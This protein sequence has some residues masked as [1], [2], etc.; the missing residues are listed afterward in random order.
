M[1]KGPSVTILSE[2]KEVIDLCVSYGKNRKSLVLELWQNLKEL[3]KVVQK[4][5]EHWNSLLME[6]M[7]P[8][9]LGS[10]KKR[11]D[12]QEW[13]R[14][15]CLGPGW[16]GKI[17]V[18][19]QGPFPLCLLGFVN[20]SIYNIHWTHLLRHTRDSDSGLETSLTQSL[21]EKAPCSDTSD[22]NPPW[23]TGDGFIN[24]SGDEEISYPNKSSTELWPGLQRRPC[25]PSEPAPGYSI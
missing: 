15:G 18:P 8:P 19:S 24:Q 9:S 22:S 12:V 5:R 11:F 20:S 3:L 10:F 23:C 25:S 1:Q 2:K 6:F 21:T 7:V 4:T 17:S 13:I 14:A 16:G